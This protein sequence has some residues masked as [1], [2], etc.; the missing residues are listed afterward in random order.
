MP[1]VRRPAI[2]FSLLSTIYWF[3][4]ADLIGV[5][6]PLGG[7]DKQAYW[8]VALASFLP[9]ALYA[10]ATLYFCHWLVRRTARKA[11]HPKGD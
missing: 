1:G 10:V 3:L 7:L 6:S 4:V 9:G 11:G 5:A 8:K 2:V